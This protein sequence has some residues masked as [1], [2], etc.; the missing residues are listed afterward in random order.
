MSVTKTGWVIA[1]ATAVAFAAGCAGQGHSDN[2]GASCA[3]EPAIAAKHDCKGTAE[4]KAKSK[5]A[6]HH[7]H[8]KKIVKEKAE[9]EHVAKEDASKDL[10]KDASK[11][12]AAKEGEAAK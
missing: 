12:E 8:H 2:M 3:G 1:A 11:D 9:D 7:R 4:C 5:V 6:K 10:S